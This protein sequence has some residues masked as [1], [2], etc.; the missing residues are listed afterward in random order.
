MIY[1]KYK[2]SFILTTLL[3]FGL[4]VTQTSFASD[5][6]GPAAV[7]RTQSAAV[8]VPTYIDSNSHNYNRDI[9]DMMKKM[10]FDG[11]VFIVNKLSTW[12]CVEIVGK[13]TQKDDPTILDAFSET[14]QTLEEIA[15]VTQK[16]GRSLINSRVAIDG[17]VVIQNFKPHRNNFLHV[18]TPRKAFLNIQEA[19]S[20]LFILTINSVQY[21]VFPRPVARFNFMPQMFEPIR[22][23]PE[24][25]QEDPSKIIALCPQYPKKDHMTSAEFKREFDRHLITM[26]YIIAPQEGIQDVTDIYMKRAMLYEQFN[27]NTRLFDQAPNLK[28]VLPRIPFI[29]HKFWL[30][31]PDKPVEL[32]SN[33]LKWA[34]HC[35]KVMPAEEGWVHNLWVQNKALLPET[36]LL[37]DGSNIVIKEIY[38]DAACTELNTDL[39]PKF[40]VRDLFES[41]LAQKKFGMASDICRLVVLKKYG[42]IY[43]DTDY[44]LAQSPYLLMHWYDSFF[45]VE[46][47]STFL[48]NAFMAARPNHP[49]IKE[50]LRLIKRNLDNIDAPDYIATIN[51]TNGWLTVA[52]TGPVVTTLAFHFSAGQDDNR[53]VAFPPSVLYPGEIDGLYPQKDVKQFGQ[54]LPEE[55]LGNHEWETSWAEDSKA[56]KKTGSK[57]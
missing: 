13:T 2:S 50:S 22:D 19:S 10:N 44:I 33:Y 23:L 25:V 51:P 35:A 56:G 45:G 11:T 37:L 46:P 26:A 39:L 42:G 34:E 31:N 38:K 40:K 49:I 32:P 15:G 43:N 16:P 5:Y 12:S 54:A 28:K 29:T 7:K 20:D 24:W 18:N 52:A 27:F 41:A 8:V 47:M 53:D 57:G 17:T 9:Y 14:L 4:T 55:S 3:A 36:V 6:T 1:R 48:C 21:P 30:T